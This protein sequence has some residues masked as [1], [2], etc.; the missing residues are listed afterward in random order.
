MQILPEKR[1]AR[2]NLSFKLM[3]KN[4]FSN[5]VISGVVLNHGYP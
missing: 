3:G 2:E 4:D 1:C 5:E